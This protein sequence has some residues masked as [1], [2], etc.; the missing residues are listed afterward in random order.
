MF[1]RF[2]DRARKVVIL[3][4]NEAA[5]RG[6]DQVRPEHMLYGLAAADGLAARALEGLGVDAAAVEQE[7]A[8]SSPAGAP[9]APPGLAD[10]RPGDAEALAAIGIDLAEIKRRIEENF[11]PGALER[12]PLTPRG[13]LNWAGRT[14]LTD[15]SKLSLGLALKEAK[16]LHHNYIGTEHLLLGLLRVAEQ[17]PRG[18]LAAVTLPRLGLDPAVT[19]A[20]VLAEIRQL[21]A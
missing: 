10:T 1:E 9:P 7:I 16:A 14:P 19:R 4:K 2:S 5:E 3:A 21:Q 13:P 17:Q 12:V 18:Q 6:D 15:Q 8:R 11:G 20:R